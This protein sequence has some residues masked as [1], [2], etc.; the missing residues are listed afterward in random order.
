M[1][2]E[3]CILSV[4]R[5][6]L[7][8]LDAEVHLELTAEAGLR[9][10]RRTPDVRV[11]LTDYRLPGM[12]GMEFFELAARERPGVRVIML[13]GFADSEEVSVA[14]EQKRLFA[15]LRKP[16]KACELIRLIREAAIEVGPAGQ[17]DGGGDA[18]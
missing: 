4:I 15:L 9:H 16:W 5:R 10:L 2:D 14:L 13:S 7:C 18:L 17:K 3:P 8:D 1:D 11:V 6:Q 12:N